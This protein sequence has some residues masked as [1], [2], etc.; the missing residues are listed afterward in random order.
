MSRPF[1]RAE[2]SGGK[3]AIS[4][5]ESS[6]VYGKSVFSSWVRFENVDHC[7]SVQEGTLMAKVKDDE[8]EWSEATRGETLFIPAGQAFSLEFGCR[9]VQAYLFTNGKGLEEL[10]HVAGEP[11]LPAILPDGTPTWDEGRI[12]VACRSL[13]VSLARCEHRD[14]PEDQKTRAIS[15]NTLQ[16]D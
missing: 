9:Y 4:S 8:T 10:I 5:I 12:T 7:F 11:Y 6:S 3:F 1:M 14:L 2:K 16:L 13:G 15:E